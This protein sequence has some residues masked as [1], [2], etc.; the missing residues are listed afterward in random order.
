[1]TAGST[2]FIDPDTGPAG[3]LEPIGDEFH[4]MPCSGSP[5]SPASVQVNPAVEFPTWRINSSP[6]LVQPDSVMLTN[7]VVP[8]SRGANR[9]STVVRPV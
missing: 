9:H 2:P 7:V 5:L 1:L 8:S 4:L 3:R 6:A